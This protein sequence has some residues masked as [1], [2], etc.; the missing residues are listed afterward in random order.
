MI[1]PESWASHLSS[2]L[3]PQLPT[4]RRRTRP[5]SR[6]KSRRYRFRPVVFISAAEQAIH[7]LGPWTGPSFTKAAGAALAHPA[8]RHPLGNQAPLWPCSC[9]EGPTPPDMADGAVA[10]QV[11]WLLLVSSRTI[12]WYHHSSGMR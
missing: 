12:Y 8:E 6:L 11:G 5:P 4:P 3:P 9:V 7:H 2:A 10:T 1:L